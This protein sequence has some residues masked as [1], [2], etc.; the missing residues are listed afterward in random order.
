MPVNFHQR[1]S[2]GMSSWDL[3]MSFKIVF[4]SEHKCLELNRI[5]RKNLWKLSPQG[6]YTYPEPRVYMCP[7]LYA[8]VNT[9]TCLHVKDEGLKSRWACFTFQVKSV[10]S[11]IHGWVTYDLWACFLILKVG[12]IVL[13]SLALFW[14]LL[15]MCLKLTKCRRHSINDDVVSIKISCCE[16]LGKRYQV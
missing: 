15:I 13:T 11:Y 7:N 2:S 1:A 12:I 8:H 9:C 6:L 10:S 3:T 14:R 16:L 4:F 5:I